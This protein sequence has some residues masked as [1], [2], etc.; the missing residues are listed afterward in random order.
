MFESNFPVD[1]RCISYGNLWNAFK[2]LTAGFS[3]PERQAMFSGTAAQIY[4]IDADRS[5]PDNI[6]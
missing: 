6:S 3:D 5:S 1:A 2:R 4:R